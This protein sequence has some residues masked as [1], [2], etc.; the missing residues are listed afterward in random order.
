LPTTGWCCIAKPFSSFA[1]GRSI[2]LKDA[3]SRAG[4]RFRYVYDMGDYWEHEIVLE[5]IL[6]NDMGEPVLQCVGGVG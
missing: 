4:K 2:S 6:T 3:F 1:S 5:E